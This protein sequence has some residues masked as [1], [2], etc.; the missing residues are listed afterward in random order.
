MF[1]KARKFLENNM[2]SIAMGLAFVNGS[3]IRPYID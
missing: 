1:K 2:E 3:D